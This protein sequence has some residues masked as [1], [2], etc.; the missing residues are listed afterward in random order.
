MSNEFLLNLEN[1]LQGCGTRLKE[2]HWDASS[3][4]IHK[5]VD[6]FTIET[7]GISTSDYLYELDKVV[8]EIVENVMT[9]M[10][11]QIVKEKK[12]EAD[13]FNIILFYTLVDLLC[14]KEICESL[15]IQL[16]DMNITL[17]D[18]MRMNLD[19]INYYL[20]Q[21]QSDKPDDY[22][23]LRKNKTI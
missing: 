17:S 23:R 2:L 20:Q 4:S 10:V 11:V 13:T 1:K 19:S 21:V 12:H 15:I 9:K 22:K 6:E 14:D 18:K 7:A 16:D 3:L 8:T 5:L